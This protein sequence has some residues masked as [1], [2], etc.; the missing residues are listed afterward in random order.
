M[1]NIVYHAFL[2]GNWKT[3][4]KEQ[5]DRL[6]DSGLYE[7]ANQ[8]W[9]TVNKNNNSEQELIQLLEPFPKINIE[10]HEQNFAEYPGIKKVKEIGD[11]TDCVILYFHT[12]GVSNNWKTCQH[13]EIS[14]EKTKNVSLWRECLEYFLIDNWKKCVSLLAENDNVGVSCNGGWYWGNFWWSTSEHI[15]KTDTVGLWDRWSY[16]AWLNK[17]TPNSKNFEFFHMGF[18]P[19]LSPLLPEYYK[20]ELR[21]N[22]TKYKNQKLIVKKAMYGTPPFEID[23]GYNTMPISKTVDVTDIISKLIEKEG[24]DIM[25]FSVNND[26]MEGDPLWGQRKFLMI[27]FFPEHHPNVIFKIAAREGFPLYFKL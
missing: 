22:F 12:K 27:E 15:K 20:L 23:E 18:D 2:T 21:E 17:S 8:I 25:N 16:E 14:Q 13:K 3:I 10:F 7:Q 5:L 4:V 1:I 6:F 11:T 9:M 19:Y 24:G 26:T